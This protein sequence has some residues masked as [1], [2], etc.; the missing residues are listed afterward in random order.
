MSKIFSKALA[1]FLALTMLCA[2]PIFAGAEA[3]LT[4]ITEAS[5][6]AASGSW[7]DDYVSK[8]KIEL[9][10]DVSS[11][12]DSDV[13]LVISQNDTA[14]VIKQITKDDA[15][16]TFNNGTITIEFSFDGKME[17]G[18]TYNFEICEGAFKSD[19][20]NINASFTFNSMGNL[21]IEKIHVSPIPSTPIE[22]LIS[23]L[24]AS[25]YA[26]LFYP[27]I[28]VLKWFSSL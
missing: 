26:K 7:K 2:L 8:I 14:N 23:S 17:H 1:V 10:C 28:M 12:G 25:K 5:I 16:V 21:I 20:G 22:R 3:D 27:L 6:A 13:L 4:D 15:K 19:S 11:L 24:S 18:D 9:K